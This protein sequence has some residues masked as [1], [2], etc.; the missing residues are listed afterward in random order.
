[1]ICPWPPSSLGGG[2][3]PKRTLARILAVVGLLFA[4]ACEGDREAR[5]L[6]DYAQCLADPDKPLHRITVARS[7][8][9]VPLSADAMEKRVRDQLE[10][11]ELT[12]DEI[13]AAYARHCK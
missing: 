4:L 13:R 6:H 5:L 8:G 3:E 7:V 11:G 10:R 1:M 9:T 2:W 12:M